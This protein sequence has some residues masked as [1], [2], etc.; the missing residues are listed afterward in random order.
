ML[1]IVAP[2]QGAQTPGFLGPWV[3]ESSFSTRLTWLSAVSGLDLWFQL[4]PFADPD[5]NRQIVD[6]A[7]AAG[8]RVVVLTVDMPPPGRL[9]PLG[10]TVTLPPGVAYAHHGDDPLMSRRILWDDLADLV[11]WAGVPVVVKGVLDGQDAR[12]TV[13]LGAAGVVV[14]NH[15]GRQLAGQ[16]E[17][18]GQHEEQALGGGEGGGQRPVQ[19]GPVQRARRAR[20]GLQGDDLRHPAPDVGPPGCAPRV[21]RLSHR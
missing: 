13:E 12:R 11:A 2:G 6:R 18:V 5:A 10:S 1:A 16:L 21:R 17:E 19:A 7:V 14:S 15:G 9:A 3:K 4:Y 8:A 20:L